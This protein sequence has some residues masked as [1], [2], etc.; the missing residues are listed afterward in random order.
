MW[1]MKDKSEV[2]AGYKHVIGIR[3]ADHLV[4]AADAVGTTRNGREFGALYEASPSVAIVIAEH[5]FGTIVPKSGVV[6][7]AE[8]IARDLCTYETRDAHK[9]YFRRFVELV[10]GEPL[11]NAH[12]VA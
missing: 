7:N 6:A 9:A 3:R 2:M 12:S 5:P 4:W 10:T 8:R 11:I 1:N